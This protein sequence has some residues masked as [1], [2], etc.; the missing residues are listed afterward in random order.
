MNLADLSIRR[1]VFATILIGA[2]VV[3]GL[4][5]Y[6]RIST[7]LFPDIEFPVVTVTVAYPGAD[8]ETLERK[9]ADKLEEQINTLGGVRALRSM[10]VEGAVQVIVEFELEVPV[11]RAV[12][13]VR[14][15]VARIAGDLP[16]GAKPPTVEKFDMGAE[17]VMT[18]ALAG[19]LEPRALTDLADNVVKAKLQGIEGVGAV[20]LVGGREREVQVLVDPDK[21]AGFG[22]TVQDVGQAIASQNLEVPAGKYDAEGE[23]LS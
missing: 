22:L 19:N 9:V 20:E 15:R 8:P 18:I 23:E 14:D 4:L 13:D 17:P 16:D 7:Q 5:S 11:D 21:L 3:F 2:L 6:P 10:S 1:P 12:Q